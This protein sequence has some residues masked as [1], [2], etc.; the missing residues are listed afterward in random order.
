MICGSMA[1]LKGCTKMCESFGLVDDVNN[2]TLLIYKDN[3]S[4]FTYET[5]DRIL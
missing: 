5:V 1:M 2:N 3:L 4:L